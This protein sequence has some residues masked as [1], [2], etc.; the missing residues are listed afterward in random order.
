MDELKSVFDSMDVDKNGLITFEQMQSTMESLGVNPKKHELLNWIQQ[1]MNKN[2]SDTFDFNEFKILTKKCYNDPDDP[3]LAFKKFDKNNNG[4]IT[5][6]EFKKGLIDLEK[7]FT[8]DEIEKLLN[9]IDID[10]DG[11]VNYPEFIRAF[12]ND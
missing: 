8:N 7:D 9:E 12:S 1:L 2:E 4:F 11:K 10:C 5:M 6:N 3:L